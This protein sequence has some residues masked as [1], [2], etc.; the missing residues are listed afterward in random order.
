MK[1]AI[2]GSRNLMIEDLGEYIP[3]ECTEIISGGAKGIDSCA[4][5]YARENNYILTEFLP[6]YD[7]YGRK[8]PI[9][10]N[11][12]IVAYSELV[13][14]FWDGRSRGTRSVI[15][16]CKKTGKPYNVIIMKKEAY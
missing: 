15:S 13:V 5:E 12:E 2:I 8:A 9:V 11:Y 10:R 4:A 1:V 14:A 7:K 6:Q 3:S 16:Y